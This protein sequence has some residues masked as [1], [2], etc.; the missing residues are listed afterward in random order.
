MAD[1]SVS[2]VANVDNTQLDNLKKQIAALKSETINLQVNTTGLTGNNSVVSQ[3][4]KMGK[5]AGVSFAKG[6]SSGVSST[7][8]IINSVT[9]S[10]TKASNT[11]TQSI[12]TQAKAAQNAAKKTLDVANNINTNYYGKIK[13][14]QSKILSSYSD[15]TSKE[16]KQMQRNAKDIVNMVNSLE[17]HFNKKTNSFDISDSTVASMNSKIENRIKSF[18]NN[19]GVMKNSASFT[20]TSDID[21][22]TKQLEGLMA[23]TN[24]LKS[25][26][27]VSSLGK[28]GYDSI[29]NYLTS[30]TEKSKELTT[31][32]Q[33]TKDVDFNKVRSGLKDVN[34][35]V[36]K[37]TKEYTRLSEVADQFKR[38][39][40][41]SDA[42]A[43]KKA[44]PKAYRNDTSIDK[45]ISELN[46]GKISQGQYETLVRDLKIYK[47]NARA[48]GNTGRTLLQD[49]P[50]AFQKIGEFAGVYGII[51]N[52]M[53]EIPRQMVQS[54]KDV[55]AAQIELTKVSNAPTADLSAYWDEAAESAK[56]YGSTISDVISNTA[57]WS[58]LG[59]NL[60]EAKELSDATTLLQNVGDNMTQ[61]SSAEGLT[62]T[63]R[64]FQMQA[65]EVNKIVDVA[66]EVANTQ[67][68]DTSGLF[69]GLEKSSSALSA[70]GNNYEQ[71]V[72][73][74]TAANSVVQDPASVGNALKT[75]SMRIRGA[76][77][78]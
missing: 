76:K 10:I 72:S 39:D 70:A 67:P 27:S 46:D 16:V 11:Q 58:R 22:A 28:L 38:T 21:S 52:V 75:I 40:T 62:S 65:D 20:N 3:V 23:S 13:S 43:Y 47:S 15:S 31:Y 4:E 54:V 8:Q 60:D 30:A 19:Y 33:S 56:K 12:K 68:I 50:R 44:N 1:Y 66:N 49:L 35:L 77:T 7:Q 18:N 29:D 41:L 55:N 36:G 42:L 69:T 57:D 26:M 48:T 74:I 24:K 25:T 64:G 32:L 17:S 71:S 61:E 63:L 5:Q 45:I 37:S 73:L 78:E 2:I 14:S 6:M 34:N 53:M 51:Q 9:D 59:Y